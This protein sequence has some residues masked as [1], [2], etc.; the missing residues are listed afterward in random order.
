M[1]KGAAM[2]RTPTPKNK[3]RF[4]TKYGKIQRTTPAIIATNFCCFFPYKKY[5]IP[6][7]P[8]AK[9]SINLVPNCISTFIPIIPNLT[10]D[11]MAC[12]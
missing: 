2:Q 6:N 10:T 12:A 3:Y 9:L 8:K 7:V 11:Y 5:A 1:I 4:D